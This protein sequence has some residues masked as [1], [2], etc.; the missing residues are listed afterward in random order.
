MR[1]VSIEITGPSKINWA[2]LPTQFRSV[3]QLFVLFGFIII[4]DRSISWRSIIII[5]HHNISS[6]HI[7]KMPKKAAIVKSC[8]IC[9]LNVA[10]ASKSCKCGHSFFH[11]K[12]S[13]A[14]S[15]NRS[16]HSGGGGGG[17]TL[18][19]ADTDDRRRTSRVRREK[20]NYYDSQEFEKKKKKKDRRVR[21]PTNQV[22]NLR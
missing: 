1:T 4:D 11:A 21:I 14:R 3:W 20:P 15:N 5:I 19:E 22:H 7:K 17:N 8:P 13:S 10:V 18:H 12:R 9:D 6:P 16:S 2:A